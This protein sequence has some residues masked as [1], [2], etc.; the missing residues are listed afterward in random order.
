MLGVVQA[1][2]VERTNTPG[3][4]YVFL[5]AVDLARHS[6]CALCR[7]VA[8]AARPHRAGERADRAVIGGGEGPA[9]NVY[10]MWGM[11]LVEGVGFAPLTFLLMSAVLRS[12]DASF[13]EAALMAGAGPLKTFRS[14]TLRLGLPGVLALMLLIGIRAFES[15]EV[16]ALVGLAGNVT[17]LTTN[18]YQSSKNTGAINFGES[19]AY[20]VCLL[21]DRR[22]AAAL[23][24]PARRTTPTSSRPSPA[25]AIGR[26]SSI[27][28]AGAMSRRRSCW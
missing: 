3:R 28:A 25:R 9:L 12:T 27:S 8:A 13:E 19:G 1:L 24:Q 21:L 2:I 26:A 17:V 23:A 16:P 4:R 6:A 20:S 5:G 22:A 18:I 7:G 10:S 11:I 15:F 14:I